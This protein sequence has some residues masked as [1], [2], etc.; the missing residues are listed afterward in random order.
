MSTTRPELTVVLCAAGDG[1]FLGEQLAALAGQQGEVPWEFLFVDNG[2]SPRC[3]AEVESWL[4]QVPGARIVPARDVPGPSYGRTKGVEAA[5]APIVAFCDDDD[6]VDAQWVEALARAMDGYDM[7]GGRIRVDRL[8]PP[9]L[10]RWRDELQ[11]SGLPSMHD[12]LPYAMS[13]NMAVRKEVFLSLGGFDRDLYPG[14]D[15]DLSWRLQYA[16]GTLGFAADAVIDYRY[17]PDVRSHLRQRRSYGRVAALLFV[18]HREHGLKPL[19][20][21]PSTLQVLRLVVGM[22]N[23]FRGKAKLYRWLGIVCYWWS[24]K[25]TLMRARVRRAAR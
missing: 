24:D 9:E 17:R 20:L 6:V 21:W 19:P 12:H 10:L 22:R 23:V 11:T 8:N 7:V 1:I 16:G 4:P 15:V 3:L 2:C 18:K 13:C 25:V 5:T 14:E